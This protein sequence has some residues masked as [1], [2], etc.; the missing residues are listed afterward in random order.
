METVTKIAASLAF[1]VV[2]SAITVAPVQ[3]AAQAKFPGKAIR[4]VTGS[5]PGGGSDTVARTLS[6]KLNERFGQPVLV[7]NRAG[8]GGAIGADIVAKAPP[9]GYTWLVAQSSSLVVGPALQKLQYE[10]ERDF[11]P[12]MQISTVPFIL[13]VN[14]QVPARS[15]NEL[16]QLA[17]AKPGQLRYATSGIG[18]MAHFAM[19]QF[20]HM[21]GVDLVH[22]PYR[23]S[24]Q[25]AFDLIGGQVQAAFNNFIPTLPHVKSGRLRALAISSA[26][27]AALMPDLPT[28]AESGVRGYEA[29]QWYAVVLPAGVPKS[30]V[31][32]IHGE[33]AAILQIPAVRTRLLDEGG[34]VIGNTPEQFAHIISTELA[35]WSKLA[36]AANIRAD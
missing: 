5:S 25:A 16:I 28:V 1:A 7:D 10:P 23:G 26:K 35:K 6:E 30:L 21:A 15:V 29:M 9:D 19:E 22:V 8:A 3:G 18:S 32:F 12:V 33:L 24:P 11:A 31:A 36:K 34:E 14:P 13:V 2:A 20:K 27:R 4:I 17:K